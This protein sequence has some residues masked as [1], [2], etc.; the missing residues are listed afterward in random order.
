[1]TGISGAV[2]NQ[3]KKQTKK[4]IQDRWNARI[5]GVR[6]LNKS[7]R[8]AFES[9]LFSAT[10]SSKSSADRVASHHGH[11]PKAQAVPTFVH[12]RCFQKAAIV[13]EVRQKPGFKLSIEG[14]QK[15]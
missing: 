2:A 8:V 9:M 1:M 11:R 7:I 10:W 5:C 12:D 14:R 4:A 15:A 3:A 13:Q 6:K